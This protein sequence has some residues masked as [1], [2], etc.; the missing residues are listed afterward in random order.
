MGES[1]PWANI[2]RTPGH[3]LRDAMQ[4]DVSRI[5]LQAKPNMRVGKTVRAQIFP[6]KKVKVF[7]ADGM[8]VDGY[9]KFCVSQ[10]V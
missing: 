4:G 3:E 1:K 5:F 2:F 6:G 7:V 10:N 8:V 9:L